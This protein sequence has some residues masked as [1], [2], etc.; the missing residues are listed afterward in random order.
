MF[1]KQET[2]GIN[3]MGSGSSKAVKL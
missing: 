1:K 2:N 3:G